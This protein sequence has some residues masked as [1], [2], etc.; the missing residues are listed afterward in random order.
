MAWSDLAHSY[1]LGPN[2]PRRRCFRWND[3]Y[4]FGERRR[5]QC[6]PK[7]T[8]FSL[9]LVSR[10]KRHCPRPDQRLPS[11]PC[12]CCLCP[13]SHTHRPVTPQYTQAIDDSLRQN[14]ATGDGTKDS[15]LVKM[16]GEMSRLQLSSCLHQTVLVP[17]SMTDRYACSNLSRRAASPEVSPPNPK[18]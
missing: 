16:E 18:P 3:V 5:R 8:R 13:Y 12:C 15:V 10:G 9:E 14:V 7:L 1:S 4:S 6:G 11:T 2:G 17:N